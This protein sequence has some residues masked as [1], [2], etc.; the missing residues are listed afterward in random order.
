MEL[1]LQDC[2]SDRVIGNWHAR[3]VSGGER[4]R[5]IIALEILTRP[6]ILFLDEP[7]SRLDNA[8]AFFVIQALKN[9]AR[10]LGQKP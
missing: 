6:H 3:G 7:T 2:S 5:V 9:I 1:G 8:S 10:C 4:K